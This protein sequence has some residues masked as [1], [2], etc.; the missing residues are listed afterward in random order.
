M[1]QEPKQQG[2]RR[3]GRAYSLFVGVAFVALIAIALLNTLRTNEGGLL[4]TGEDRGMALP[5]FAVPEAL[6]SQEGDANI[7][8][9][10]CG[11]SVIPCPEEQRRTAACEVDLSEVIRV[12]D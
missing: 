9:D 12:C 4:G 7:Y 2:A 6:G 1:A 8:Q 11:S 3:P 10:D 5:Q